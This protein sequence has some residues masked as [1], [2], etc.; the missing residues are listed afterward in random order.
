MLHPLAFSLLLFASGL[1]KLCYG[2]QLSKHC[3]VPALHKLHHLAE[4]RPAVWAPAGH[5]QNKPYP[6]APY[7]GR[8]LG[9][10]VLL[11]MDMSTEYWWCWVGIAV[12]VAYILLLNGLIILLLAFLP[13]YGFNATIAKTAE[14]LDDRRAALYGE[15][16][17]ANDVVVNMPAVESG[18]AE[19]GSGAAGD[20]IQVVCLTFH[21]GSAIGCSFIGRLACLLFLSFL[22]HTHAGVCF[23]LLPCMWGCLWLCAYFNGLCLTICLFC[24]HSAFCASAARRQRAVVVTHSCFTSVS[25][26]CLVPTC[27]TATVLFMPGNMKLCWKLY[28]CV[29]YSPSKALCIANTHLI[30]MQSHHRSSM[31]RAESGQ[32]SRVQSAATEGLFTASSKSLP[33]HIQPTKQSS[34]RRRSLDKGGSRSV[35]A[36]EWQ[37]RTLSRPVCKLAVSIAPPF[38]FPLPF[39]AA[40]SVVPCA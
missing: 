4:P 5:W 30:G 20:M 34:S 13:A 29:Q 26:T 10:G 23:T 9:D 22:L 12:N 24:C 14:E 1:D 28:D 7:L 19:N 2:T 15:G 18:V 36:Q 39:L 37:G 17:D 40:T 35:L 11:S 27:L 8:T 32:M 21:S 25:Y 3:H 31:D 38:L 33:S 6:Y 16:R